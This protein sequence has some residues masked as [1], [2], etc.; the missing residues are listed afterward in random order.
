MLT[1]YNKIVNIIKERTKEKEKFILLSEIILIVVG[2]VFLTN[3]A[4][5]LVKS[6]TSIAKRFG[7]S[8]M[9]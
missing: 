1:I 6:A 5:F 9:L 3:G 7:V 4:D 8:E 2:F